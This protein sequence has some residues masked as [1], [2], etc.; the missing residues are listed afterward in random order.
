MTHDDQSHEHSHGHGHTHAHSHPHGHSH[1]PARTAWQPPA[2]LERGAG[3]GCLLYV[4]AFSGIAGDMFLAALLD[5]GVPLDAITSA[6][7][8]LKIEAHTIT[9]TG[10][11][12]SAIAAAHVEVVVKDNP[13]SRTYADIRAMIEAAALPAGA[14][15]IA[16]RAFEILAHAEATV[17]K[18]PIDKVHFHEVGAVDSI[19]DT[20]GVAVALDYLGAEVVSSALPLGHGTV[21]AQHGILPLPA[22]ATVLCLKGIPTYDGGIDAELV[23]PTGAS[24]IAAAAARFGRWPAIEPIATGWGAGTKEFAE[25]PNVVRLV[26]GRST[27]ETL[28]EGDVVL[29]ETNLDDSTPEVWAHALTRALAE[30]ALDAWTTP[31][32]MKKGRPGI[33][34]SVLARP[35]TADALARVL[36]SETSALGVR[37]RPMRRWERTR[38]TVSVDTPYGPIRVKVARGDGLPANWSPEWDDCQAAA[39]AHRVPLKDVYAAAAAAARRLADAEPKS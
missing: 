35:D 15:T 2:P 18:M 29:L 10:R 33:L 20:V 4:D 38:E 9:V 11:A 12:R 24:L 19:V 21:R 1:A 26:L 7:G 28:P 5:L 30:G 6:L 32:G 8:G 16:L 34:L 27:T 13:P 23:T 36:L 31:I 14:R 39:L 37:Q 3:K 22:P 25:R 17:H